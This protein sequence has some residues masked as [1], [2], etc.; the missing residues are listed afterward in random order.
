MQLNILT[1]H[2]EYLTLPV[3]V[4]VAVGE[5]RY[6]VKCNTPD[7]RSGSSSGPRS[8]QGSPLRHEEGPQLGPNGVGGRDES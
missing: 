6:T 4:V 5:I 7:S 1:R 8:A 2:K 3:A